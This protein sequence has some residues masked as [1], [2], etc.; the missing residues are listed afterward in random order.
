MSDL[1]A[2][3][4]LGPAA[5]TELGATHNHAYRVDVDAGSRYLL[6]LHVAR[7]RQHEIDLELDW[8]D[9]LAARGGPSVPVPQRTRDGSWTATVEVAVPDD[10]EIG[11]RRAVVDASGGRVE[12]RLASLLTWH[13]GEMLS[14]LPASADAGPFA[15]TL[16][17]LH[18][19]GADPA[20]V[21]LAGQRRRYDADYATTRLERLVEGYPGI[22]SDGSTADA[23]AGAIEEL[24]ATLAEAGPP[25]MVHGDYHPGNLI[26][27]PTGVSVIDFDRCG[28]GPAGLDVAAAI[29]YLAPRQRAQFH[30]AY[31]AAGGST[32]VPDERFGA[33]IFL[34]YLDNV[35]HL[36]SLPSERE[37]MPAN[38]AQLAAIARAVVTG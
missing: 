21:G 31:T 6:R 27:G 32:G 25:I 2:A 8:L 16:A 11:L 38:I 14:S 10:D 29:M 35:T 18:A 17:A 7:R 24:R 20:A 28:L 26:Q 30:R 5:L 34:A 37:R 15:E 9:V 36:A 22:M 19:V 33:F 3:W 12:R 13:D 4:D 23:L 1:L